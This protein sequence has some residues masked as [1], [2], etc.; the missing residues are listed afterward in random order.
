MK[1]NIVIH[2]GDL[3]ILFNEH[4]GAFPDSVTVT[5]FGGSKAVSGN[6]V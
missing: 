5:E 3:E 1:R 6:R 4:G 2:S